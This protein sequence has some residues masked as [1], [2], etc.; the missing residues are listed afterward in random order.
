MSIFPYNILIFEKESVLHILILLQV[1]EELW[2]ENMILDT[3]NS[4]SIYTLDHLKK[5]ACKHIGKSK[6]KTKTVHSIDIFLCKVN[7]VDYF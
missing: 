1:F 5:R 3:V 4:S 2:R 6:R 7:K